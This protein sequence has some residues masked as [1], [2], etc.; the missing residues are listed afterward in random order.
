MINTK[1][2]S[3]DELSSHLQV[4]P[5]DKNEGEIIGYKAYIPVVIE[6]KA[7]A[8][9]CQQFFGKDKSG[10]MY[11]EE[12]EDEISPRLVE[13]RHFNALEEAQEFAKKQILGKPESQ[14]IAICDI[15]GKTWICFQYVKYVDSKSKIRMKD[16]KI[17]PVFLETINQDTI[18][19]C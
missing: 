16:I 18:K 19:V 9:K 15:T 4:N 6:I 17:E 13:M 5:N 12:V 14:Y 8:K 7:K 3:T 1:V 11:F 10:Y 2:T